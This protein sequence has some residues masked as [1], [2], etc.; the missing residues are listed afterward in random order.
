MYR[1][2]K[3]STVYLLLIVTTTG[4][5]AQSA[6]AE[7]QS[8]APGIISS[9]SL[10]FNAAFSPDGKSLYFTRS[11]SKRTQL[12]YSTL[13]NGEWSQPTPLPFSNTNYSD[14]DPAISPTGD[15]YF[16]SNRPTHPGDTTKDFDIWKVTRMSTG[17]WS[18]PVNVKELNSPENEYYISFTAEGDAYFSS[19]RK[20]CYGEEDIYVSEY[21]DKTFRKPENLG[22]T[23]NT[24][25]SE[26]DPFIAANGSALIFTSSARN[27]SF[28]KADLYWSV[29]TI[30]GWQE[31]NHF[32]E[33]IN[34]ATRDYCPY[35]SQDK[36]YFFYSSRGDIKYIGMDRLPA[37]LI[38]SIRAK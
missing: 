12:Y 37:V 23:V 17:Q 28:G 27:D 2:I 25:H 6:V 3:N 16:I 1:L 10:D 7:V 5:Y 34:T 29:R 11:I 33:L 36:M 15:L 38:Q 24:S 8:F 30:K 18:K 26:Y 9:D 14:A 22:G 21:K 31:V 13:T 4:I 35:I 19:S 20:D 32:N